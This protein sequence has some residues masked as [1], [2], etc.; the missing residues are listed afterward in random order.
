MH[1]HLW[2]RGIL[3]CYEVA[4]IVRDLKGL[5]EPQGPA[6]QKQILDPNAKTLTRTFWDFF[7]ER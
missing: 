6:I 3:L 1:S 4:V 7:F 5:F 2:I